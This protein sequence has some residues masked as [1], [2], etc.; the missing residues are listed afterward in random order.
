MYNDIL[1]RQIQL[2]GYAKHLDAD[3]KKRLKKLQDAIL[4]T[5]LS[6]E[7][8]AKIIK[9]FLE[10]HKE[11]LAKDMQKLSE[12]EI[13]KIVYI[14]AAATTVVPSSAKLA[15]KHIVNKF[16]NKFYKRINADVLQ[17]IEAGLADNLEVEEIA[18]QIHTT[19]KNVTL[20]QAKAT[21]RTLVSIIGN[22]ARA[23][24]FYENKEMFDVYEY[25]ATLDTKT[26]ILCASLDGKRYES[27]ED[28]QVP[29]LHYNCRSFLLPVLKDAIMKDTYRQSEFGVVDNE[30]YGTWLRRQSKANIYKV[31]GK[32][33]G[34]LFIEGKLEIDRFVDADN[35]VIPLSEL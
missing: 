9:Q 3:F 14:L 26:S 27:L 34:D 28:A 17:I 16:V 4:K 1:L 5:D 22:E 25:V 30:D 10:Q 12:K 29:P 19:F 24:A 32:T 11:T 7:E 18:E 6:K 35:R 20:A 8:I 15:T 13:N 33:R 23:K 2:L 21:T 31:L